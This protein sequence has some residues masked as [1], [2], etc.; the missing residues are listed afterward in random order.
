MANES[1]FNHR[2]RLVSVRQ[3][4]I[5]VEFKVTPTFTESRSVDYTAVTPIHMPGSIQVY[6]NTT[7]RTFSIGA[8]LVSRSPNEAYENMKILQTL[9]TWTLPYFGQSH[10]LSESERAARTRNLPDTAAGGEQP[11]N[12]TEAEIAERKQQQI[13]EGV[14]LLGAP[15][16]VLYLYAHSSSE[17]NQ[18]GTIPILRVNINRIPVVI[19]NLSI[20]YPNDVDYF[21]ASSGGVDGI[22]TSTESFP[23]K[24]EVTVDCVETHSPREYE[25]FSLQDFYDG[26]LVS[27]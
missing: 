23:T 13:Q 7:S 27:F 8:T 25:R 20:V 21:P 4:S 9:R 11:R 22:N 18:R 17:N 24:M 10:G 19:A 2:V 5:R 6:K 3:E 14:N 1:Y 15:P 26:K 12:L 16:M